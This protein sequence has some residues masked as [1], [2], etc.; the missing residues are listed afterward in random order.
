MR[1]ELLPRSSKKQPIYV[2]VMA[3]QRSDLDQVSRWLGPKLE[4]RRD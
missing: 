2:P 4:G 3:F 1:L